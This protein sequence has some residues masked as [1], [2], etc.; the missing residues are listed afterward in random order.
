MNLY[1]IHVHFL[2]TTVISK[3]IEKLQ[4]KIIWPAHGDSHVSA[5]G[6]ILYL[7]LHGAFNYEGVKKVIE[8]C[9]NVAL[10]KLYNGNTWAQVIDLRQFELSTP[11]T[12]KVISYY[13]S[14]AHSLGLRYEV[15]LVTRPIIEEFNRKLMLP[16]RSILVSRY[17]S[18]PSEAIVFLDELGFTN[19]DSVG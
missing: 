15:V 10:T 11:D 4:D 17:F 2:K 7:E 6:R 14:I 8:N 5:Q 19:F 3:K 16:F 1:G 13:Y 12:Q 18:Q 9:L